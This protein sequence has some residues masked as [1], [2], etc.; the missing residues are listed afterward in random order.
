MN[1][2]GRAKQSAPS[3]LRRSNLYI[4]LIYSPVSSRAILLMLTVT[5][6]SAANRTPVPAVESK[7]HPCQVQGLAEDA[8]CATFPVWENRDRKSGRKIGLNIV[9]LPARGPEHLSD[10]IFM[11]HGG[12]GGAATDLARG[13]GLFQALRARR[14]IVLVDQRGTG[15]SNPL[16]CELY[17]DPPALQKTMSGSFPV[18]AVRACRA[19]L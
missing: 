16:D 8:L 19:R 7:P 17:S 1:G 2:C 15:G 11:L 14:D 6:V 3:E 4:E 12:P 5:A 9:V 10:A 18:D 13:L